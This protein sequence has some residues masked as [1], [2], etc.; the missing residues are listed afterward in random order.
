MLCWANED[1]YL[2]Q[3][4]PNPQQKAPETLKNLLLRSSV[5]I[6]SAPSPEWELQSA[7]TMAPLKGQEVLKFHKHSYLENRIFDHRLVKDNLLDKWPTADM[8]EYNERK[9]HRNLMESY[10]PAKVHIINPILHLLP[11]CFVLFHSTSLYSFI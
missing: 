4:Y 6:V 8:N 3:R 11:L 5:P 1:H 10:V 9:D 2:S 7:S